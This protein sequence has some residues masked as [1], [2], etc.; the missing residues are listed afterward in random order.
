MKQL[1]DVVRTLKEKGEPDYELINNRVQK[2]A[3]ALRKIMEHSL[4]VMKVTSQNMNVLV[5]CLDKDKQN[6]D[7]MIFNDES[8]S[9]SVQQSSRHKT[10]QN[11]KELELKTKGNQQVQESKDLK[12]AANAM[13][14]LVKDA[15]ETINIFT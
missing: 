9:S 8:G 15:E 4:V 13:M 1:E 3:S 2:T 6:K 12:E 5:V 14:M 11:A 10:R 7:T